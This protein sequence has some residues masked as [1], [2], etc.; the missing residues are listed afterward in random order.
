[1]NIRNN[2]LFSKGI[3]LLVLA[4]LITLPVVLNQYQQYV[5]NMVLI[6]IIIGLSFNLLV[7]YAGQFSF[8][9]P[10]FLG[11]G[12]Y[13]SCLM[14]LHLGIPFW[15]ALPIC[16]LITAMFG[17]MIGLPALRI[18]SFYLGMVTVA[19]N[20]LIVWIFLHWDSVTKGAMGL[21]VPKPFIGGFT[22]STDKQIYCII[23]AV[24]LFCV[25]SIRNILRSKFGRAF[26]AIRD[27]EIAASTL[28]INLIKYKIFVFMLS[29]FYVGIAGGLYGIS[30]GIIIPEAFGLS[31]VLIYFAIIIIGGLGSFTGTIL[32]S[33]IITLLPEFLR[34]FVALQEILFGVLL[35]VF[36]VFLPQGIHGLLL[37]M[38][39][40][41][42]ESFSQE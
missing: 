12:A 17:L 30:V 3:N 10:A 14:V 1:M 8:A 19:F 39:F 13:S 34:G 22:F 20:E 23:L 7:G 33:I 40:I 29:A 24:T 21:K 31:P 32:S 25:L 9:H 41:K 42:Q 37:K 18:S 4:L 15:L 36:I 35:V 16:G 5:L 38:N 6:Y 27:S 28:S 2:Y 11:I 26:V